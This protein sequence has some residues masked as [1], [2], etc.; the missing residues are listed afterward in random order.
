MR[1]IKLLLW[2]LVGGVVSAMEQLQF[3]SNFLEAVHKERSIPTILLMQRKD[4]KHDFLHGLYPISWPLIRLDETKRIELVNHFNRDFLVLVYMES[5]EDALLLSALAADLNHIRETRILVWLQM[6]PSEVFLENIVF[7]ASKYKFLN[8]V[9]IESTLKTRRLYPFPQP[10]VQVIDKPFEEKK[11]YPALWRNFMGKKAFTVSD[12]VPPRNFDCFD[13]RT[14]FRRPAGSLYNSFKEFTQRYNITMLLE[15]PVDTYT[16]QEEIIARTVRG[17]IDLALTGQL[18]SFRHPNGSRTQPILGVTA[19]SI[20]VP[21]GPELPMFDRF[22]L[23]FGL[24]TPI[25]IA[26]YYVLLSIMELILGTLSDRVKRH[27]RRQKFLNLVLNL[28]VF[29]CILSLSTPQGNRL[30]S[31]QGQLTMVMSVTG[32]I[33]SCYVAAQTS[34]V[35]TMKPQYRHIN[36]FQEL[37]DSN[38]TVICNHLNYLTMKQQMNPKFLSKFIPNIWIVSSREQMKMIVDLNTSYAYQTFSYNRD[39]FTVLQMHTT[40]RALCRSQDLN[41]VS[42]IAYTAVLE[43]NSIYALPL[44]DYTLQ[45]LSAGLVYH[46]G[47]EAIRELISTLKYT[48]LE[49]LP[50]VIGYQALKLQDYKVCWVVI[51]IGG[52]LAFCVFIGEIVVGGINEV[53]LS[54]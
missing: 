22:F 20:T 38:I 2:L 19:L 23:V 41:V 52:A 17:E 16:S 13:P 48:Q 15:W 24:A 47:D 44:Q 54:K 33:L 28:R 7:K 51:L 46:W 4:H 10:T 36:N 27:P 8:L 18:I 30:R 25:T 1:Q 49:K 11:I 50:I 21:C 29:S 14:G 31:V 35:L 34:T 9:L 42:G 39:P 6:S 3:L 43:K 5:D 45:V 12:M 26:G 32:L 37:R 40:R 53:K